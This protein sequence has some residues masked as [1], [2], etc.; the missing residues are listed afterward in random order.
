MIVDALTDN[1]TGVAA[2]LLAIPKDAEDAGITL[3]A[4]L[5]VLDP[6]R[7][8]ATALGGAQQDFDVLTVTADEPAEAD[9]ETH[10]INVHHRQADRMSIAVRWI[11]RDA[12]SAAAVRD[13]L[14]VERATVRALRQWLLIDG[15]DPKRKRNGVTVVTCNKMTY[16]PTDEVF[17]E[18]ND[19]LRA[20]MKV[21]LDLTVRDLLP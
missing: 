10:T 5:K 14:Y 19:G 13:A 11:R 2:Q 12:D 21:L 7:H 17:T 1:T 15:D 6:T 3:D 16:G 20:L 18:P 4:P 8:D 9:G